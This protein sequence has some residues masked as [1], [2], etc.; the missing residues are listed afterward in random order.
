MT[1]TLGS[2]SLYSVLLVA[3]APVCKACPEDRV[4]LRHVG[5]PE[6]E[7]IGV[8]EIVVAAHRFIHAEGPHE[9]IRGGC[10]AM[11]GIGVEVV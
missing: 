10:H 1:N 4:H 9:G 3:Q 6:H 5:A 11:A 8:L 2:T 7:G